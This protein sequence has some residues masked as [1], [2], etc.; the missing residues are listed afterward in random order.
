MGPAPLIE[1]GA[2]ALIRV[3]AQR[4]RDRKDEL[5]PRPIECFTCARE[6]DGG[7]VPMFL[8]ERVGDEDIMAVPLCV[9]CYSL[10]TMVHWAKAIKILK[11]MWPGTDFHFNP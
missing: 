1:K 9:E 5:Y 2:W 6:I 10:P 3:P 8:P 4:P 11:R 7:P